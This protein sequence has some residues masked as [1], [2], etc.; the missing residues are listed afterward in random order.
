MGSGQIRAVMSDG[1]VYE[2]STPEEAARFDRAR[3]G[4]ASAASEPKRTTMMVAPTAKNGTYRAGKNVTLFLTAVAAHPNGIRI[5]D[6]LEKVG[7]NDAKAL[8]PVVSGVR[9]A[10]EGCGVI[11]ADEALVSGMVGGERSYKAGPRLAEAMT[12]LAIK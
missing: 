1:A 3:R 11:P 2:F 4:G 8:G 5:Q 6:M 10:I 9:R 12:K 7:F